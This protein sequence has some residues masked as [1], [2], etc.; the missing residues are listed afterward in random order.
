LANA[1]TKYYWFLPGSRL[2]AL[3]RIKD[4]RARRETIIATPAIVENMLCVGTKITHASHLVVTLN[5]HKGA[6]VK[7]D[8][9]RAEGK[10]ALQVHGGQNCDVWSKEIEIRWE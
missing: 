10:F 1:L 5:G 7:N 9:G 3:I 8:P 2:S 4:T 6:K